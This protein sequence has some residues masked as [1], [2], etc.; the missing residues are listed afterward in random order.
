M[1]DAEI[2]KLKISE[3]FKSI[4]IFDDGK[5]YNATT[6]HYRS[7]ADIREIEE[8]KRERDELLML[9]GMDDLK[10]SM[11]IRDLEQQTKGVE[12]AIEKI[13]GWDS[14]REILRTLLKSLRNQAKEL[15]NER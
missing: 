11:A 8:L 5:G 2:L 12:D 4:K 6:K 14:A 10:K 3:V 9:A 15:S 13:K 1:T 7:L